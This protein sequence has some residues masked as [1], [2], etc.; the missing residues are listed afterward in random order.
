MKA[1]RCLFVNGIVLSAKPITTETETQTQQAKSIKTAGLAG[2]A[3]GA[4]GTGT[5]A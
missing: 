5:T 2:L 1:C 3:C 4:T